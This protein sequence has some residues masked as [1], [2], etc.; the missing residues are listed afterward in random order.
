VIGAAVALMLSALTA[1]A[2]A[3]NPAG[4]NAE[5]RGIAVIDVSYIF[6]EHARFRA[7]MEGMKK[8]MESIEAELKADR[9][10]IAL[11]EQER[12]KYNVGS[13]EYKKFDEE[14]ARMMAEFNLK[15]TRLRKDF[16]ER[17]AKVYYQ[18][19]LEVVE[20]IGYYAKRRNIGLVIRF[21][22]DSVDPNR[23][24]D[25]LREINKSIP[26][27]DNIDITPDVLALLN[28]DQQAGQANPQIGS[29]PGVQPA[30]PGA[31]T[32]STQLPPR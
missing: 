14:V 27:H 2:Q 16:L 5:K 4:A 23:R 6:K 24:E 7:T 25:V 32:G 12:N 28:R 13:S 26:Y 3:P 8:E 17:E 31:P 19:Y 18:T 10:R 9:D 15:M 29:R 11:A 21:N 30:R 1:Q 20:A 22:G